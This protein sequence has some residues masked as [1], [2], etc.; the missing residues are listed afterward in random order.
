[1]RQPPYPGVPMGYQLEFQSPVALPV[2]L[3]AVIRTS[4]TFSPGDSFDV[5]I[6][7]WGGTQ[8]AWNSWGSRAIPIIDNSSVRTNA[9]VRKQTGTF[10]HVTSGTIT[11]TTTSSYQNVTI[12]WS[13]LTGISPASFI[14]YQIYRDGILIATITDFYTTSYID[15][16]GPDDGTA[17]NYSVR[18]NYYQAGVPVFIDSLAS[19]GQAYGFPDNMAPSLL[20]L[21]PG[22][23]SIWVSFRDNSPHNEPLNPFRAT[24]FRIRR[25][26]LLDDTFFET[27]IAAHAALSDITYSY[28]DSGLSPGNDYKYEIWAQRPVTGGTAISK[29]I[30]RT[31]KT[32]LEEGT[33]PGG[34]GGCFIATAAF[35]SSLANQVEILRQFRDKFLLKN[36]WGRYF[37]AW[38][39]RW[40]P[41]AA[42]WLWRHPLAR[43]LVRIGLYPVV[44]LAWLWSKNLLW[45]LIT[46]LGAIG[47][48]RG[49]CFGKSRF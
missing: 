2:T 31:T 5:G 4:G 48:W 21:V 16:L 22:R 34:G 6:V 1:F 45:L 8:S 19:T 27:T 20:D 14:N 33:G 32:I 10:T 9:Y 12:N 28:T 38:Y 11:T 40:S 18:M 46:L 23:T 29:P 17:H 41:Q 15:V 47:Y 39:Y 35:G 42:K 3:Y 26:R 25:T 37:V 30:T 44:I 36:A 49:W 43:W 7:G 24:S 13:N